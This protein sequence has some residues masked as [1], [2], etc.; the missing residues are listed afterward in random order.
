MSDKIDSVIGD[1]PQGYIR[2]PFHLHFSGEFR[3]WL[4]RH[5]T[6]IALSTYEGAKLIVIGPGMK[7][8]TSVSERNF[9][10]CMAL[11]TDKDRNIYISTNHSIWQLENGLEPGRQLEGW[12]R[13]YLPRKAF[14]TGGVD[15]HDLALDSRARLLAVVTQYNCIAEIGSS[16]GSFSPL[17]RPPFISEIIAEDRCHL[18]GFCLDHDGKPAYASIVGVSDEN[19]GWREHREKGGVIVDLQTNEFVAQGLSMPHTPRIHN[20]RLY[21]LEAGSGW[22]C[23]LDPVQKKIE[24][25][26]WR[27]GFLRGLR[28]KGNFAFLCSS[29]PR[30]KTFHGLPL[31]KELEKRNEK[32]RCALDIIDLDKMAV[33]HS[34]DI[35]GSVRELYDVAVLEKCVQPLV[36]GIEGDEMRKIVVLG[37]DKTEK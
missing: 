17:W 19:D 29:E 32:P 12:D 35:T 28:F 6:S 23:S 30:H 21:F 1:T 11:Y 15:I 31:Q 5:K 16:K 20:N 22:F 9:E 26:L 3:D 7:G 10:R 14:I 18:N 27:P 37:E 24:R 4:V 36:Y 34:L 2:D 25:L 33:I 8:G 13:I